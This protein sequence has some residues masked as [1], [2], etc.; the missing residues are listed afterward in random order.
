MRLF[1]VFG[2]L[3]LLGAVLCLSAIV[4]SAAPGQNQKAA[5]E[6]A[7]RGGNGPAL[8][9]TVQD[10]NGVPVPSAQ[11]ML[12]RPESGTVLRRETD[13]AGRCEFKDLRAGLYQLRVE[14]EGFYAFTEKKIEAGKVAAVEVTLNHQRESV[15]RVNVTYSPPAIDLKKTTASTS[16]NTQEIIELPYTVSRDIRYALPM[17]PQVLQDGT[18]QVHIAGSDTRQT[19]DQLDGFNVNAPVS[20][21]LTMRV[22]VDAVRHIQVQDSRYP[23]EF[24][25]G[26]GGVLSLRTGMGDDRFRFTATDFVPSLQSRKGI[27]INTWTPRAQFSGPIK[28]GK[29]WFLLAPEGEY[30]QDIVQ[31][32]PAGADRD[33]AVRYSGLAK[34]QVNLTSGNILTGGYLLNR[35]RS[36]NAGLSRFDPFETTLNLRQSADF[37]NL[38]DQITLAD[39]GLVEFGVAKSIFRSGFHPKGDATYVLTP[40]G[41]RGN[42]F[43]TGDGRS[44]RLEGIINWFLPPVR[45]NGRHEIKWGTDLDRITFRQSYQ[46]NP[47]QIRR[48]DGTLSR[49]VEFSAIT[50]YGRDNFEVGGYAEDHWSVSER[51]VV[52][53]GLRL[54]WDEIVRDAVLSPRLAASYLATRD[55]NTKITGGIGV[56]YDPSNL[57]FVSRPQGG[58]RT[59]LFYDATGQALVQPPVE[60]LFQVNQQ[61]LKQ[62]RFL[63][64]SVGVERKLPRAIYLRVG[65]LEKRGHDGWTFLNP[66]AGPAGFLGGVYQ[67]RTTRRDRYDSVEIAARKAFSNGH[68][69]FASYTRSSAR[70]NAVLDFSLENPVFARQAEGPLPWDSPDRLISWGWLPLYRKFSGAYWLEWRD[71]YP[72]SLVNQDQQL[73]GVPGSRRFPTYFSLNVSVERRLTLF[74]LQ[75][76]LRLGLD[77]ATNRHNPSVVDNNVDSPNF[78]TFGGLQGRAVVARVRLLGEK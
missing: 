24:G 8:S 31:E 77:D 20:G 21:L 5:A 53:P 2:R 70:S 39:G 33:S 71:G 59:D 15:E 22:S 13:Y 38:K 64:W 36:Y 32:L 37:V 72:F 11:T 62:P 1:V 46:R 55:G 73:V 26:S 23:A 47:F 63:N 49:E 16:L 45:W 4:L 74:G 7:A 6:N 68:F 25:K 40:E 66:A 76:A 12:E 61:I 65:F 34:F 48:E 52:E 29:A 51:W 27:H 58:V 42:Y 50:P 35:F 30:D 14:K 10:E 54:D 56:Y 67:L 43:E 60:T 41:S 69:L 17:L 18:G 44:S 3:A 78:L 28:K 9:I 19:Y 75:W 57:D